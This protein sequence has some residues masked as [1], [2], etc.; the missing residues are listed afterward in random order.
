VNAEFH[1]RANWV[2]SSSPQSAANPMSF[3]FHT[4]DLGLRRNLRLPLKVEMTTGVG[5]DSTGAAGKIKFLA[6]C[7]TTGEKYHFVPVL[8]FSIFLQFH[9]FFYTQT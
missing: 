3:Q 8:P 1:R 7:D 4:T 6:T 2:R 5:A 9:Y